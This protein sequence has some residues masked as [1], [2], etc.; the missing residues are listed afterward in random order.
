MI[1]LHGV[2]G[3]RDLDEVAR[4]KSLLA[5]DFDGTLA[6]I[7]DDRETARMDARSSSVLR[8]LGA[9]YPCAI[10]TGRSI[11]DASRRVERAS[12]RFLIGNHGLEGGPMDRSS[13]TLLESETSNVL[14]ALEPHLASIDGV[15]VE[16]K[17]HSLSVHY[18]AAKDPLYAKSTIERVVSER[19][20]TMRIV[21]GKCVVNL[22]PSGAPH[23]GDAIV[24][25][26]EVAGVDRVL[27]V[28]DDTT[29]EDVFALEAPWLVSV[30]VGY[31]PD[32]RA[33]YF[34]ERQ[35]E[36]VVLMEALAARRGRRRR[37]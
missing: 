6:P 1:P 24:H 4:G 23:K 18:R 29:D 26:K 7:V 30:R 36:V 14:A 35:S 5:F 11:D 2:E 12:V 31:S 32:S 17:G 27:F 33:T 37:P 19:A 10:V 9:L 21:G 13:L 15:E 16:D 22:V 20:S 34:L 8:R 28:G 25:L 3:E